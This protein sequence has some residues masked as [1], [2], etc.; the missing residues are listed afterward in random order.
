MPTETISF[1]YNGSNEIVA[2]IENAIPSTTYSM[3]NNF[4]SGS[5]V[6][7]TATGS[8]LVLICSDI[9]GDIGAPYDV[10]VQIGSPHSANDYIGATVFAKG[11]TSEYV[12]TGTW[13]YDGAET[14]ELTFASESGVD[15]FLQATDTV[16]GDS[17]VP[18][19]GT[20]E[21]MTVPLVLAS[22]PG[23]DYFYAYL[24]VDGDFT[25]LENRLFTAGAASTG[26]RGNPNF[27]AGRVLIALDDGP[28]EP[29]PTWT[30]YDMLEECRCP[31]FDCETGRQSEL[32]V[33]DTGTARVY[34]ND[35]NGTL[36]DGDLVGLQIMLQLY[37]PVTDEW[38][39]RWRGHID[40]INYEVHPSVAGLA[41]VQME[42]VG[43]FD[44]LGGVT[45]LPTFGHTVPDGM[46]A[47]VFY[48]NQNVDDRIIRLLDN[49]RIASS[50]RVVF[51]GNVSLNE[52]SY[53]YDDVI[54]QAIR[55]AA[56]AEF[57]GIANVY[58][59]RFGRVVFHGRFARF[60]PEGTEASGANWDF[61]RWY[62]ATRIDVTTGVA[63][64]REFSYNRPRAR[65]I[66]SY[67][68]WPIADENGDEFP[69]SR[70]KDLIRTDSASITRY[71]YRGGHDAPGL[72]IKENINN[73]NTG[74]E[75]CGLFGDFYIANYAEIHENIQ[76]VT[77]K[78]LHPDDPRAAA[79]WDAM[80]RM[81]ISDGMN[82]TVSEA[83]FTDT[84]YFIDG[85]S[86]Q[87]RALNPDFDHVE[88]T[89]NLTPAAYYATDV[90]S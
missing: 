37:N 53:D 83:G 31:G 66:N 56:D 28:L 40:D 68:A 42:C 87:C 48:E 54:L 74:A 80:C 24:L 82:L 32:D 20:G 44:Y 61:N 2:T 51:T 72:L 52:T 76:R 88:V 38:H 34:F 73:S 47:V 7:D 18:F 77:L 15:Y 13:E 89:P 71:A 69:R 17:V 55:D 70:I 12:G 57:P 79:T 16:S 46:E 33:T 6:S 49:A 41:T 67:V 75:E 45:M 23:G 5:S 60:D 63:Q 59:D 81:D 39:P 43:I 10:V 9:D 86:V 25:T 90:F 62:A 50:M 84:P 26:V 1:V 14:I 4:P 19:T 27:Y 29:Y 65:I 22:T 21:L 85:L 36:N 3:W 30:R 78:S 58:E 11:S 8:T 35:R 64:I